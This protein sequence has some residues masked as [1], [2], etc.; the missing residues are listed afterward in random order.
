MPRPDG[1]TLKVQAPAAPQL[2][3]KL[4]EAVAFHQRG[5]LADAERIYREILQRQPKHFDALHLLGVIA[6]Q[7]RRKAWRLS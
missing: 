7:T 3:L 4:K 2:Q 5:K 1:T 6:A